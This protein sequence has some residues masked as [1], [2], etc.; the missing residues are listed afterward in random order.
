M[1]GKHHALVGAA[2]WL[3]AAPEAF[4]RLGGTELGPAA[5][6]LSTLVAAGAALLPDLD[7]PDSSA[8]KSLSVLGWALSLVVAN[9]GGG[10]RRLTH[11]VVPVFPALVGFGAAW[12]LRRGPAAAAVVVGLCVAEA[13]RP[14]AAALG[15]RVS[16]PAGLAAGAGAGWWTLGLAAPWGDGALL[17]VGP[18]D[19]SGWLVAAVVVGAISHLSA[20]W[21]TPEGLLAWPAKDR[22]ALGLLRT[23]SSAEHVVG[24]GLLLGNLAL[25]CVRFAPALGELPRS[26]IA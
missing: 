16:V 1:L 15:E 14:L 5:L 11:H 2:A 22:V 13:V 10:H 9:L 21:V 19:P 6:A 26:P 7:H 23:G 24:L 18:V 8:T 20:D 17:A 3:G 25:A 12:A 4:E